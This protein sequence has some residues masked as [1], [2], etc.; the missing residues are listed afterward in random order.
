MHLDTGFRPSK[1]GF[2][3]A[4]T[5]RDLLLGVITSRGRCGGMVFAALDA[6]L[7]NVELSEESRGASLPAHDSGLARSIWKRQ[8]Q[9]VVVGLGGNLWRFARFTYL[10]SA[11]PLGVG[12][13]TRRELLTVFDSL[14]VGRPAPLG[15]VSGIG[16]THMARN[17]Q[18]LAYAARFDEERVTIRVYDPNHP[19]R[20]DVTLEVP[21]DPHAPVLERIGT[22]VK[23]WR[24]LFVERYSPV[25][26]Q[27]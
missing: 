10:P 21:M 16:L 15:L 1:H 20:D 5:W 18:V 8:V 13:A 19:R 26:H 12:V 14:R 4:N 25:V 24:G 11:S 17:H 7:A 9:S 22:R 3:F 2:G 27:A 6:F 23:P